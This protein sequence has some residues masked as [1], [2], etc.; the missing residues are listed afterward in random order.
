MPL[1]PQPD[2]WLVEQKKEN[3]WEF[4]LTC[5]SEWLARERMEYFRELFG[6][7]VSLRVR[8]YE[9]PS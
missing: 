2:V 5:G 8:R 9:S 3:G 1:G 4:R 7:R 6:D